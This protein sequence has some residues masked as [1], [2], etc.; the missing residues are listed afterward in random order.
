MKIQL[1]EKVN[2]IITTLQKHGFEAYAVGGCVR[3]SFLGRVPGDWDITTSAAPEE[4]KS[5]FAR[6]FDTG[7]EHGTITVLLNGEG[8]EVT[9][10]RIDGKY[11]DNRHPSKVQFTRSLS[12]DLL[13][14]DFTIN[15]M[16]YNEQDGLVDLFH[17]ME[18]LK[19]GVI[20]CVG[21]AEARFSEDALRILRAIRFSAQLGFEIEKETR[22]AIR[23]LAP[24]LS[25]ISAE[26]IQ[27]ELVKLLVSDHP[28]Y[29]RTAWETGLTRE[30]LP[31]F[32][33]CMET[34]Q[35][36][37]HHCCNVGEHI[38]KSLT[39]IENDR[40]LRITMLL[41]DIAKPIVK[42][43]DENGRD[44]FKTHGPAGEKLA[45]K[46][47]RRLKFDNV[48]IRNTCRLIR[49]HDLRPTPDAEDVRR[50]VNL[51]GEELFPLYLK[52]QKADL[53]SQ[54]TYKR[55]EKLARLGGVTEAYQGILERGECTSLKTLA[56]SGK[57]LIKAGHP[58][59][60][61]LGALLERLLDCVLKDPTLNTKEKLLE[62]AEKDSIKTE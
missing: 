5:L 23:K 37:P 47:L 32:D 49:Y 46:I 61:A 7:I 10:Y 58:A 12:E 60:P 43:T 26:R 36:T 62:T 29:L 17:G 4:T 16:A 22:Q 14:R 21:N 44:H 56:V 18:D 50:A 11:E 40:L 9:T 52:V 19:K 59:G 24:N 20:R 8:F 3:D 42:K 2:R 27:T 41:H 34:A 25:Y 39:E 55:E 53:L 30:F 28:D 45:G 6:T 1:P 35:N 13:R 15:A 48:T 33:A 31:E 38:L 54:S 51:I 57:D